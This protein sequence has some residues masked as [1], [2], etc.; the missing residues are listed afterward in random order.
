[1]RAA[2]DI[3]TNSL[4]LLVGTRDQD[5]GKV[6]VVE[7][8]VQE[9]RLGTGI[10]KRILNPEA[11]NR[12][13]D[14]LKYFQ[15]ILLQNYGIREGAIVATSAVRD[16]ENKEEFINRV[17]DSTGWRVRVLSGEEEAKLSYYGA[18]SA[19]PFFHG[20]PVV[21]DIGGGSTEIIFRCL[22]G[23][24]TVSI[25]I[26]AVRLAEKM[27][28]A[29]YLRKIISAGLE[30][31]DIPYESSFVGV[32]GTV[33]TAAAIS[34]FVQEYSREAI[35]GRILSLEGIREIKNKL[36]KMTLSERERVIG[37]TAKRADIIVPGLT[38]LI[39]VMEMLG[40]GKIW[41]SDAGLLDGL[42]LEK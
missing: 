22:E 27:H 30:R 26:G 37:L 6:C 20:V 33:T 32:G 23:I 31:M 17:F 35:H 29:D 34:F 12:T 41:V 9:T 25:N 15:H 38:I 7:Q 21:I 10:K 18:L 4:R 42:I 13:I 28:P 39:I 19:I 3:G 24:Q 16:A 14:A 11:I 36:A 5:Q 40:A 8:I 1:M 2:I